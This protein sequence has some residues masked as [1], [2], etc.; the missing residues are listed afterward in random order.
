MNSDDLRL[1][2]YE[3]GPVDAPI[4]LLVHGYP[5]NAGVF[6][7]LVPLLAERFRV[8][9]YDVRGT[10]RSESPLSRNGYRLDRLAE[11]VA[12]VARTVAPRP[13]HLLGHDWGS[14]QCWH[15]VADQATAKNFASYTSISGPSVEHLADWVRNGPRKEV[16]EQLLRSWYI[17]AFQLHVLPELIMGA[18]VVRQRFGAQRRDA[19]NGIELYRANVRGHRTGPPRRVR[20]PVQQLVLSD[21]PYVRAATAHAA[22]PWCDDLHRRT[23]RAGHWAPRTAPGEIAA[24]L[25]GFVDYLAGAAR[26]D[27]LRRVGE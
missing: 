6:D 10:G 21:D 3:D 8:V 26:P 12:L 11:D 2:V 9:R 14:V 27:P 22:D 1:A 13:V 15:A 25:T 17:G 7:Q 24:A 19:V 4:V 16:V 23:V 5:D 20:I 18:S